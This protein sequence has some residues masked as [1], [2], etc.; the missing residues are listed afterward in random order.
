MNKM[1]TQLIGLCLILIAS[2]GYA[3]D[4]V[5]LG[6]S[7]DLQHLPRKVVVIEPRMEV[8]E[9]SAGGVAERVDSWTAQAKKNVLDALNKH[10]AADKLFEALPVPTLPD[11]SLASLDEHVA[12]YDVVGSNAHN[13]GRSPFP[14]WQH[15]KQEFDYTL[16]EGLQFLAQQ[17]GADAALFV[18]G[19]DYISSEGRK[20][21][22]IAAALLGIVLPPSP[23]FLSMGLVDLKSGNILWMNYALAM[24]TKDLRK[25]E[26]VDALLDQLFKQYP[27][28]NGS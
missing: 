27:G 16:G 19:E 3:A 10:L 14:A 18:V 8:K 2:Q 26:D 1:L 17:S 7:L 25:T 23:T 15:K 22:R 9:L 11:E 24:D 6:M 21:A 20:A 5:S 12:L 28:K 4:S 13:F